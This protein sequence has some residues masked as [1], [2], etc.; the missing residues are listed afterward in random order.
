MH[1]TDTKHAYPPTI[2]GHIDV[3]LYVIGVVYS[4]PMFRIGAEFNT[5]VNS[6]SS[7]E[8]TSDSMKLAAYSKDKVRA[9]KRKICFNLSQRLE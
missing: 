3:G 2:H 5:N 1:A 7:P 8:V 9:K 6:I 4:T